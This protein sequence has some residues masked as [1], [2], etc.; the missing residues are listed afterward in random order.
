METRNAVMPRA[1]EV[2]LLVEELADETLVYDLKRHKA[3]CLNRTSALVWRRCDGRTTVAEMA[4]LLG[5]E[6]KIPADEAV[7]WLALDRLDR[8]HLLDKRVPL[9]GNRTR[10]TRREVL[11]SLRRVAGISLLLPVIETIRAPLAAAQQSN[12]VDVDTCEKVL[13]PPQC[14]NQPSVVRPTNVVGRKG[15]IVRSTPVLNGSVPVASC[16]GM[17]VESL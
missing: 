13:V 2:S 5:R 14:Y 16:S 12:C 4:E 6:L 11:R 17:N 15:P 10:Y 8:A 3:R 7:V 9:P 1:R